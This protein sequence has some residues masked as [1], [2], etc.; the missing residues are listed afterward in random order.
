MKTSFTRKNKTFSHALPA[1]LALLLATGM[2]ANP[3]LAWGHCGHGGP[4]EHDRSFGNIDG[5]HD[6]ASDICTSP[7][8]KIT[9]VSQ[10]NTLPDGKGALLKGHV[11]GQINGDEFLFQDSPG[12]APVLIKQS[13]WHSLQAG[14]SALV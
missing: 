13:D 9:T 8:L 11:V 12:L 3:A 2:G 1:C 4:R 6:P 5:G 10:V 7:G 14:P